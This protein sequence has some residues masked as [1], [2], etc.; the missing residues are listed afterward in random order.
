MCVTDKLCAN[1]VFI[2]VRFSNKNGKIKMGW[3][4]R[5]NGWKRTQEGSRSKIGRKENKRKSKVE[6][7]GQWAHQVEDSEE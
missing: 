2:R 5:E 1:R 3:T 7:N 6:M 4:S